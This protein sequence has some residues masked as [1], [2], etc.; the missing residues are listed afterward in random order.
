M[1]N[2]NRAEWLTEQ[3]PHIFDTEREAKLPVWAQIK[4]A[5]MRELLL[6]EAADNDGLRAD[7][8]R[9]TTAF[10]LLKEKQ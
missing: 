9:H 6:A 1:S 2:T 3:Y 10:D 4:F 5:K 8:E 7:I